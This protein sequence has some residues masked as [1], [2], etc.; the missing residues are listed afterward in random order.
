[1]TLLHQKHEGGEQGALRGQEDHEVEA[2]CH[3]EDGQIGRSQQGEK[4]VCGLVL[5]AAIRFFWRFRLIRWNE[6]HGEHGADKAD[7]GTSEKGNI[8]GIEIGQDATKDKPDRN[9]R[10]DGDTQG[11]R[12]PAAIG[13]VREAERRCLRPDQKKRHADAVNEAPGEQPFCRMVRSQ[14]HAEAKHAHGFDQQRTGEDGARTEPVEQMTGRQIEDQPC[15]AV[16]GQNQADHKTGNSQFEPE[17]R[18][19]RKNQPSADATEKGDNGDE[20]A[21]RDAGHDERSDA[22]PPLKR[23]NCRAENSAMRS[24]PA[25]NAT[26]SAVSLNSKSPTR[27]TRQ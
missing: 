19:D 15:D 13:F 26:T 18:Q 25:P 7:G 9:R 5:R 23:P 17:R 4:S 16:R 6:Q 24:A 27:Q 11:R 1:M 21:H 14:R 10:I 8:V 22:L 20:R 2:P 12:L 3:D